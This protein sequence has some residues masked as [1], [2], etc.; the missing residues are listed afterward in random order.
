MRG[1][2]L[3]AEYEIISFC[4]H[5]ADAKA[6]TKAYTS[7]DTIPNSKPTQTGTINKLK[8]TGQN[9]T[10]QSSSGASQPVGKNDLEKTVHWKAL[11]DAWFVFY[12]KNYLI[13]PTFNGA[14]A[15]N[16]KLIV[17]R[18]R[19]LAEKSEPKPEWT[20]VYAVSLLNR[21]LT[22]AVADDWLKNNFLLNNLY[23]KFDSIVQKNGTHNNKQ[24]TGSAVNTGSILSKIN[25]MPG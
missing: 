6:Y 5:I 18:L 17:D 16:L 21:F 25:A 12:K 4:D 13:E 11:V 23:S 24:Q 14:A 8:E 7:A 2:N 1:G 19:Q 22:K 15:K 3:S 9:K 10:K 20:E